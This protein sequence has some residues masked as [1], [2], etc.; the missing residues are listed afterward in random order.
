MA[1]VD[2][3]GRAVIVNAR[4]YR[5]VEDGGHVTLTPEDAAVPPIEVALSTFDGWLARREVVFLS[6]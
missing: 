2:A 5:C 6:W 4:V 3:G 1:S